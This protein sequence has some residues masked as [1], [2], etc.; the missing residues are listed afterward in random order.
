MAFQ[1]PIELSDIKTAAQRIA[2][3]I[4]TTPLVASESLSRLTNSPVYLK[5]EHHQITNSFK[6][7][8]ASNAV[9]ALPEAAKQRGVVG[10]STGNHG[11]GLAYAARENGVR[12]IICMSQLVP[13]NKIDGIR[14]LGAEVRIVGQ[15]QDDA[16]IEVD[17]LVAAQGMTMIPPFDHPD[18]VAGQASL[19]LELFE[20]LPELQ[21]VLVPV[22][23]GGLISGVASALKALK[24]DVKIIA[25]SMER[26]AAM[27]ACLQ[28][29]KPILV[30]EEATLADSL[31]GGIGL[32]NQITFNITQNLVDEFILVSETEI[33]QAIH[34]AY[35]Q[36]RQIIEGSGAVCLAA[37]LSQ[38]VKP[39]GNTIACV[40]GGNIDLTVHH[41]IISG[42]N[43]NISNP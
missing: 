5:L 41:R 6:L 3:C 40:T 24:K 20:A 31:G 37:L 9:M 4:R 14:A 35:W 42:E 7:R 18:I 29:G 11:R 16:Q 1:S 25:V 17:H 12:C 39:E 10:V 19:G 2:P 34:H 27:H 26:G 22:S 15:S 8:G 30:K 21:N 36:E 13:Q 28:A 43:I 33:A 38:K 32:D 23:G